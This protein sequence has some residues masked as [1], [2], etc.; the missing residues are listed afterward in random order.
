MHHQIQV[1]DEQDG[2]RTHDGTYVVPEFE[3]IVS[4][5]WTGDPAQVAAALEAA[6]S[7]ALRQI[8]ATTEE[9]P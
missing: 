5:H 3:I 9:T 1:T 2:R 7:T 4:A 8:N 6:T